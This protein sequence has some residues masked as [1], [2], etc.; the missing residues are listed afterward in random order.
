MISCVLTGFHICLCLNWRHVVAESMKRIENSTKQLLDSQSKL[1]VITDIEHENENDFENNNK[2]DTIFD[3]NIGFEHGNMSINNQMSLNSSLLSN[4]NQFN[5]VKNQNNQLNSQIKD[6]NENIQI[7]QN[8]NQQTQNEFNQTINHLKQSKYALIQA[9][10]QEMQHLRF[11]FL[12]FF[13]LFFC[14]FLQSIQNINI[15]KTGKY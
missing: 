2:N 15:Q 1:N 14:F 11:F 13:V 9:T 8:Q 5:N 6:L 7:L 3:D 12:I 4:T 10:A